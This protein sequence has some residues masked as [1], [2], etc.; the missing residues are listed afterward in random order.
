MMIRLAAWGVTF[1]TINPS[2]SQASRL[3]QGGIRTSSNSFIPK[4]LK[5]FDPIVKKIR[6]NTAKLMV[7]FPEKIT[8]PLLTS[9]GTL[10]MATNG[11]SVP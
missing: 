4:P 6:D 10:R 8:S 3:H 11:G 7:A 1:Q 5:K 9:A 2:A